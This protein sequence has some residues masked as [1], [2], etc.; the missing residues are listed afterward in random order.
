MKIFLNDTSLPAPIFRNFPPKFL[1]INWKFTLKLTFWGG[2]K[3]YLK[4]HFFQYSMKKNWKVIEHHLL[5]MFNENWTPFVAKVQWKLNFKNFLSMEYNNFFTTEC[6]R[7]MEIV[8]P[9]CSRSMAIE[10]LHLVTTISIE[11]R[12]LARR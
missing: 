12:H 1:K 7:S 3:K 11:R 4:K 10:Q 2:Q 5:L 8:V 9:R 6:Q